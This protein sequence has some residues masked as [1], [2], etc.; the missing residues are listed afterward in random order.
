MRSIAMRS[1]SILRIGA[2]S[3]RYRH[4]RTLQAPFSSV[5]V[6]GGGVTGTTIVAMLVDEGH[7]VTWIDENHDDIGRFG[8]FYS[9]GVPANTPNHIL[10]KGLTGVKAFEYD[11]YCRS[12]EL[13]NITTLSDLAPEACA[14][15]KYLYEPLYFASSR[16]RAHPNVTT[17]TG[18]L[19]LAEYFKVPTCESKYWTF[20]VDTLD[21]SIH[22][23]IFFMA[24]GAVPSFPTNVPKHFPHQ[25]IDVFV[26]SHAVARF[27]D[28]Q[29]TKRELPWA[30]VGS[31][32]R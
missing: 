10:L 16:L 22:S 11:Q 1:I 28:E 20:T 29:S 26:N 27:L 12:A 17:V 19:T 8:R 9:S 14:D 21:N 31:S 2:T 23:D 32:H 18:K 24:P 25:S 5:A 3:A 15:L 6:L 4:R 7:D 13:N 30:V